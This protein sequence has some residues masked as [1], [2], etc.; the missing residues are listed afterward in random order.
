MGW[1]DGVPLGRGSH[2]FQRVNGPWGFRDLHPST[3]VKL[4][5]LMDAIPH[6]MCIVRGIHRSD[7]TPLNRV[8]SLLL[9]EKDGERTNPVSLHFDC[10]IH[11][12][13]FGRRTWRRCEKF[14]SGWPEIWFKFW[15]TYESVEAPSFPTGVVLTVILK[16]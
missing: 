12:L 8:A 1:C 3:R 9:I 6:F 14:K 2:I 7:T 10:L 11:P 13:G 5:A 4:H 16:I 15:K